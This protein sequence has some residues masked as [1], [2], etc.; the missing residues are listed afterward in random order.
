MM[1]DADILAAYL[2]VK[3]DGPEPFVLRLDKHMFIE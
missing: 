2:R 1:T 3:S